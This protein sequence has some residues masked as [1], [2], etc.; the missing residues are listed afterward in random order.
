[1]LLFFYSCRIWK[2]QNLL[3][4]RFGLDLDFSDSNDPV[5]SALKTHA[6]ENDTEEG[7]IIYIQYMHV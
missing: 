6:C 1:M 5:L 4:I 3:V 2:H 7:W